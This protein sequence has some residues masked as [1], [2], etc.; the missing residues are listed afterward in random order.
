M[1]SN[2]EKRWEIKRSKYEKG[3]WGM[4]MNCVYIDTYVQ[5]TPENEIIQ[6][7]I[8]CVVDDLYPDETFEI[9]LSIEEGFFIFL[10]RSGVISIKFKDYKVE[11]NTLIRVAKA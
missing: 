2:E 11:G 4:P 1:D 8:L 6:S 3:L 5:R 10:K 9:R 7:A